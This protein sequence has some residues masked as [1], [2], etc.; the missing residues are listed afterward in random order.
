M[1]D[2]QEQYKHYGKSAEVER[3][4][5]ITTNKYLM[6]KEEKLLKRLSR[7][8]N[9]KI[10]EVGCGE[11]VNIKNMQHTSN[12]FF[13][14]DFS[15]SKIEFAKKNVK[16]TFKVG[17]ATNL[18]YK[19]QSF[20]V[21]FCKDIL[22]HL[23]DKRKVISEMKRV[24]KKDG[25]LLI[26]EANGRN[27]FMWLFGTFIKIER[28][29]KNSKFEKIKS[30]LNANSLKIEKASF[31]EPFPFFRVLFH[32]KFG[33]PSLGNTKLIPGLLDSFENVLGFLIPKKYWGYIIYEISSE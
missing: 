6:R 20:D 26:V 1:V 28:D 2:A 17:D 13:G 10:L 11:G 21:V 30:F 18:P 7:F 25:K 5:W 27:L 23:P 32:Y 16:G 12:E 14:V 8:S 15:K 22:H 9:K 33:I 29:V 4:G 24:A 31:Y 19:N 3:V